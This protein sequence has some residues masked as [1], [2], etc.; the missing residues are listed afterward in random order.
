MST[1]DDR[2]EHN[3]IAYNVDLEN[4]ML[5]FNEGGDESHPYIA[6][7]TPAPKNNIFLVFKAH[8]SDQSRY[9]RNMRRSMM[10]VKKV[11]KNKVLSLAPSTLKENKIS[12]KMKL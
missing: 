7:A 11:M 9:E 12:M 5:Q 3:T 8:D 10:M 1:N 6:P 2:N 4:I